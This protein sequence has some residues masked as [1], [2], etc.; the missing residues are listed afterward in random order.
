MDS[1]HKKWVG[2]VSTDTER[3]LGT[4][5]ISIICFVKD[6]AS[7][8]RRCVDSVLAQ[9]YPN[10]ELVVQDGAST[11]GTL[12]IVRSYSDPR[13]KVVSEP[14][15]GP[16]EGFWKV[17][18]RCEGEI[19]GTCLSDE[20]LLPDALERAVGHFRREPYLG[21]ITCDG[22]LT[23]AA[24]DI[25]GEF[26]AGDFNLV[27]YLF[28]WYCPFWPGS[29]FRRQALIEVGLKT[30]QWTIDCLEF[31][32]WCRLATRHEVKYIPE[33]MSK[34][35]THPAQLS[36]TQ[37]Y[38]SEHF[39]SRAQVIRTMFS[40]SGF[41]GENELLL[42]GCLYN[43]LFQ[44]YSHV[45]AYKLK[46]QI[47][48]LERRLRE[49]VN[50][51]GITGR[52]RYKEYFD[53][54]EQANPASPA[55]DLTTLNSFRKTS[56][57]WVRV[58][59]AIPASFRQKLSSSTKQRLRSTLSVAVY[60]AYNTRNGLRMLWQSLKSIVG[61]NAG[62]P[63]PST[64][65]SPRIY[66]EVAQI[67]YARGQIE[68]ALQ[69]WRKAEP[70]QDPDIDGLACQ[71]M[72]MSPQT[73][74]ERLLQAQQR[75][76]GRYAR[77]ISTLGPLPGRPYDGARRIRVGYYCAFMDNELVRYML[78]GAL[79]QTDRRRFEIHGYSPSPAS[80]DV[81]RTFDGFHVTGG[82]SDERFVRQLRADGLDILVEVSGFSP[83]HRYAAMASRCAPV[84]ISYLNHTGTSAV[85]NL[86]YVFADA[87]SVHPDDDRFFTEKVWRLPGSFLCYNYDP[88]RLPPVSAPP[89]LRNGHVTFGYFGSGGKVS[90]RIVELWA[91]IMRHVP[92]S[93]FFIRNAHLDRASHREYLQECFARYGI[94]AERLR[95][96]GSTNR[97][98][99]LRDYADV[100]ISLD[101][102]PY[103]GGNTIAE[104]IWQG[105]P[106]I[107]LKGSRFSSRYGAAL[108]MA[109]GCPELVANTA[110]EYVDIA[111]KLARSPERLNHYRENLRG[112]AKQHG[113]SDTRALARKLEAAYVAMVERSAA[114]RPQLA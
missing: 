58:A 16:A 25:I 49:H 44:L 113:L 14:D 98:G 102:W 73:T 67:Y 42:H 28:G 31:E 59:L 108:V 54:P 94:P 51:H 43:Q 46:D 11:D 33:R 106:V 15:S 103:C 66:H 21:A 110:D 20:E 60:F 4:P 91:Q 105:V 41:F 88:A 30:H 27:D 61:A 85:P 8:I 93:V 39:D 92:N 32:V 75:W 34:Y 37:K 69:L 83:Q 89:S 99:V 36:N 104:P 45:R 5:L 111:V 78:L 9:S 22:F 29:F 97:L 90:L 81:A 12:E 87:V 86:D 79:E 10:F 7:T 35:C 40:A 74:Y 63:L 62:E 13:I 109:A 19:V 112:M 68:Q 56:S 23:D 1:L 107:T 55:T 114:E 84:Q 24:G 17:L 77:P 76:A 50:A 64:R 96:L 80:P 48:I 82:L 2:R 38:F 100:D 65:F 18:N 70:L 52:I 101:T 71:A 72:L 57:I 47:E 26:N 53:I 6:R 95:I 3:I